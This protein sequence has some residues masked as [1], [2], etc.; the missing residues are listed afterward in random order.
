MMKR[1]DRCTGDHGVS[2]SIGFLIIFT[3]VIMGIG[4]VTLYGYPLL[5]RQQTSADEQIME[6]NMI[7]LQNDVK[8]L[9]YKMVPYKET[10]L[11]IG[12]GALTVHKTLDEPS[13]MTLQIS[14]CLG[15]NYL[16][17]FHTGDLRYSSESAGADISLQNGAVIKRSYT[18]QGSVML[19][20][21]RWFV[22]AATN[23]MVINLV[24]INS[25]E[26]MSKTGIVTAQ[27]GLGENAYQDYKEYQIPAGDRVCISYTPDPTPD[28]GSRADFS[29]AWNNYFTSRMPLTR[30][31]APGIT[32]IGYEVT[33][34]DPAK[35]FTLVIK[36]YDVMIKSL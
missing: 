31:T 5:L 9:A 18:D 3:I 30:T 13:T 6:K 27:M 26:E 24:A 35:S 20:E 25:T 23:T 4:L 33:I 28:P 21:P 14:D 34:P 19:A 36:K 32:P 8:S 2:E 10:S 17:E 7:V 16:E 22:D 11:K 12:S 1:R 15:A 29:T